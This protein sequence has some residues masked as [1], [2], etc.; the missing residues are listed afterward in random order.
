M[1]SL[2]VLSAH[3]YRPLSKSILWTTA[4]LSLGVSVGIFVVLDLAGTAE[5][6]NIVGAVVVAAALNVILS[7]VLS[8]IAEGRRKAKD[9]LMA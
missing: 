8:R 6:F 9:R 3:G 1:T 4:A 2:N 5:S 7:Y